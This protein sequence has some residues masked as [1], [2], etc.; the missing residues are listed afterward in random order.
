MYI[1]VPWS[2]HVHI[3]ESLWALEK[4]SGLLWAPINITSMAQKQSE[5]K[6]CHN[7]SGVLGMYVFCMSTRIPCYH[8]SQI[9]IYFISDEFYFT[10][11]FPNRNSVFRIPVDYFVSSS[12]K[13]S[14]KSLHPFF[15][16]IVYGFKNK[17]ARNPSYKI[18]FILLSI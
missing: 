12:M 1:S 11:D 7:H 5:S 16:W 4:G 15:Y 17:C 13:V 10:S 6:S 14:S 18:L 9:F 8:Y 3:D 2:V